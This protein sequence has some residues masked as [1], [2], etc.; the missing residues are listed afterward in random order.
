MSDDD[1]PDLVADE[2]DDELEG[3]TIFHI[4][5]PW[6]VERRIVVLR[7]L[8]FNRLLREWMER[9]QTPLPWV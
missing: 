2:L 9:F 4:D 1:V 3:I 5:L 7:F 6:G 8:K